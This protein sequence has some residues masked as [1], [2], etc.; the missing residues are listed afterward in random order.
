MLVEELELLL[1]LLVLEEE[2]LVLTILVVIVHE[3]ILVENEVAMFKSKI[4]FFNN[5]KHLTLQEEGTCKTHF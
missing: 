5:D 2:G 1:L 3:N 4:F